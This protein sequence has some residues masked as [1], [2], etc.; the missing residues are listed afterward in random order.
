MSEHDE[1]LYLAL[2]YGDTRNGFAD[3]V[4]DTPG[5]DG[6]AIMMKAPRFNCRFQ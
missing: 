6:I 2:F 3:H 5:H 4:A 1:Q